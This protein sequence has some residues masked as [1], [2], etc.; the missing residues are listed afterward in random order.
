[1]KIWK[2]GC[3]VDVFR[4]FHLKNESDIELI[5]N[6]I[7]KGKIVSDW[8]VVEIIGD[9]NNKTGD[10]PKFWS[11]SNVIMLSELAKKILNDR[12]N[13]YVQFLPV[14]NIENKER[15]YMCNILNILDGIDY[16]K[17][18][19]K[20]LLGVHIV[21]VVKYELKENAKNIPIFKLYLHNSVMTPYIFVNDEFQQLIEDSNLKGFKFT[22]VFDFEA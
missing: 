20:K 12:F 18:E 9:S 7:D 11:Y 14:I 22:E 6:N 8:E 3:E 5:N 17:S 19:F 21:D 13:E 2:L 1:V 10:N 15:F 16:D 4:G